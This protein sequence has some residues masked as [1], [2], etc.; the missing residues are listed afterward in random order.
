[1]ELSQII[2][3]IFLLAVLILILP[4]FLR[5]NSKSKQF[6]KNLSIWS[7]IV[8]SVVIISYLILK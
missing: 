3:T 5:T 8:V 1:M 6:L 2:P 7:I 4:G